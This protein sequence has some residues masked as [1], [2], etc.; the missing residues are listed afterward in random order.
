MFVRWKRRHA[1]PYS[2]AR[3][4][5]KGGHYYYAVVVRAERVDRKPRQRVV[6][7]L[8]GFH[9]TELVP[10]GESHPDYRLNVL[11]YRS[12][13]WGQVSTR[14]SELAETGSLTHEQRAA[15]EDRVAARVP[16][17]TAE[18]QAELDAEIDRRR[19]QLAPF[20]R[21]M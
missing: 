7:H 12:S 11:R 1:A 20:L 10:K 9:P 16:K 14:L 17:L 13:F 15:M 5:N 21:Q 2:S 4:F 3:V 6:K 8:A 19:A 18:E